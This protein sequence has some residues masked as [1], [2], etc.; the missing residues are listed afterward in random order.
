[1][2]TKT[3]STRVLQRI[4]TYNNWH[5]QNPTPLKGELVVVQFLEDEEHPTAVTSTKVK[6]GD[7]VNTFDDLPY[8]SGGY[9]TGFDYTENNRTLTIT[10]N[11]ATVQTEVVNH[12]LNI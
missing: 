10:T 5:T 7:G 9:S 4:D 2:A 6:I 12:V 1:M 11:M 3:L 8:L